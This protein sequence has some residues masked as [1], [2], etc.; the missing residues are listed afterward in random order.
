MSLAQLITLDFED[1]LQNTRKVLERIPLEGPEPAFK[2]HPKSAALDALA[3]HVAELPGW[4]KLALEAEEFGLDASYTPETPAASRKELIEKF[5][6]AAA[7]GRAALAAATEE[8]MTKN[9]SFKWDGAVVYTDTR[10]K[11]VRSFL[12]HMVH[13]RAQL[14]VYLRLLGVPVPGLYGP[15]ADEHVAPAAEPATSRTAS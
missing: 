14:T 2:P 6:K 15:S 7:E 5:E 13:H 3:T 8:D 9:W 4:M 11:V 12:N 10:P 1:E